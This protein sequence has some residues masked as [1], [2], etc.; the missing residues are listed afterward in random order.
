M[1][2][3]ADPAEFFSLRPPA[4]PMSAGTP[5]GKEKS[6]KED[7]PPP[8][9]PYTASAQPP[10]TAPP[11]PSSTT[12]SRL[13]EL[14]SL[15]E[16]SLEDYDTFDDFEDTNSDRP[17]RTPIIILASLLGVGV[18]AGGVIYAYR[19][20]VQESS[21]TT[22]PVIVAETKAIKE[23]PVNPGGVKIPNQNKLIYDR[24]LGEETDIA[25][26]LVSREEKVVPFSQ[27]PATTIISK[28]SPSAGTPGSQGNNAPATGSSGVAEDQLAKKLA[29]SLPKPQSPPDSL[30]AVV[31]SG[32]TTETLKLPPNIQEQASAIQGGIVSLDTETVAPPSVPAAPGSSSESLA[33]A[34]LVEDSI[35]AT[36]KP[37]VNTK[38]PP[39]LP[40]R[41]PPAPTS[42]RVASATPQATTA[43]ATAARSTSGNFVIQIAAFRSREEALSRFATLKRRH[44]RLLGPYTSFVQRADLGDQGIYY[45]L[46]LG[47]IDGKD[48]ASSL[49][50]SLLSAGEKDCLV[51]TR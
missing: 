5:L 50:R 4:D 45:R 49:C 24:I 13:E 3:I 36:P 39:V 19:Q 15:S 1:P 25:E 51:R 28:S 17:K 46:R 48:K 21:P 44:G 32:T 47:P 43:P 40:R 30:T 31:G 10:Y 8:L 37:A 9:P 26:R 38:V 16:K 14:A 42:T 35:D 11:S 33:I 27:Q 22:L 29:E 34:K 12:N 20:G 7:V 18:L 23:E 2:P 6:V 41:K